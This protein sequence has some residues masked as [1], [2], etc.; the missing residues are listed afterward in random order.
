MPMI[1]RADGQAQAAGEG[2]AT[3]AIPELAPRNCRL[4]GYDPV[5]V[6]PIQV[7]SDVIAYTSPD[8]TFAVTKRLLDQ[9]RTSILI[10][11]YDF[12]AS[13]VKL[14]IE[15]ALARGVKV[16]LMLDIDGQSEERVFKDLELLGADCT[17]APACS[18][19]RHK[20]FRSS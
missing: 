16:E 2:T 14:L 13:H 1:L 5:T 17:P 7:S 3:A 12:T 8:S 11:I 15:K 18:S 4:E 10:G 19:K 20:F 9:A 6:P